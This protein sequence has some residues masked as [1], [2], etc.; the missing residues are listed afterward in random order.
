MHKEL[1]ERYDIN[2][3]SVQEDTKKSHRVQLHHIIDIHIQQAVAVRSDVSHRLNHTR[4]L[5]VRKVQRR[6]E[7]E[8]E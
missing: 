3:E 2:Q 8:V 7:A 4:L 1:L 6:M 5:Q